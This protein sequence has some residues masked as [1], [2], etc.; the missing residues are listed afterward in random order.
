MRS[1]RDKPLSRFRQTRNLRLWVSQDTSLIGIDGHPFG[2][3]YDLTSVNQ[4]V[5][6]R[7]IKGVN[8]LLV[9]LESGEEKNLKNF[10]DLTQWPIDLVVRSSTARQTA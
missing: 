4:Q 3:F 9:I 8:V 5:N 2:E 1:R 10:E 6:Q 7:G